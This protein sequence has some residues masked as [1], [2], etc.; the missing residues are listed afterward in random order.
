MATELYLPQTLP[1]P[2]KI[3]SLDV[4]ASSSVDRG[5]RLLSYSFEY[6]PPDAKRE[7]R[8][9]TWDSTVEGTLDEW[10]VRKGDTISKDRAR[11]KPVVAIAE[12]CTHGVQIH[13]MC[14]L[15]GKDMTEYVP[16]W[17]L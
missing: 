4:P 1:Y 8:Y 12:P 11:A 14:G 15:C 6:T 16:V 17:S 5:S 10:K 7:T 13:G 3:L 2:I 9:G